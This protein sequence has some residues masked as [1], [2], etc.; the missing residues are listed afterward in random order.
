M[1]NIFKKKYIF[2]KKI[3]VRKTQKFK[4]GPTRK[5]ASLPFFSISV[6]RSCKNRYVLIHCEYNNRAPPKNNIVD[7]YGAKLHALGQNF[8]KKLTRLD[9]ECAGDI[10]PGARGVPFDSIVGVPVPEA[11]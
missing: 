2:A 8:T 4:S 10:L 1:K 5:F 6:E 3:V 7:F 11:G 9:T